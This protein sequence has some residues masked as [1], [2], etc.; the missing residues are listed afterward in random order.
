MTDD[1][2]GPA[3]DVIAEAARVMGIEPPP[4]QDFETAEM[5]PMARSFYSANKRVS[6]AKI[7]AAGFRFRFPNYR[8]SLAQLWSGGNW[9][10]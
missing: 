3:Q 9:K 10:G 7:R 2:P 8:M 1:E 6:N 5:T 4:E